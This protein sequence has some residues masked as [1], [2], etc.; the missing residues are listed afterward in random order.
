MLNSA[1][2]EDKHQ[3]PPTPIGPNEPA[4]ETALT[5]K[6]GLF[7]FRSYRC[8]PVALKSLPT[9]G[10]GAVLNSRGTRG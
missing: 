6:D 4:Y 2:H 7:I 9:A 10:N 5:L 1:S 8:A 3:W